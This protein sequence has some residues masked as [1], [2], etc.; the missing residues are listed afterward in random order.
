V[1]VIASGGS[2]RCDVANLVG[3]CD[4]DGQIVFGINN[5]LGINSLVLSF[6]ILNFISFLFLILMKSLGEI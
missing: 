3:T 2:R 6:E 5:W 1:V 4:I